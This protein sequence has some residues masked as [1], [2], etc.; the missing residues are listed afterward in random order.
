[1][2]LL[3]AC[4]TGS[5]SPPHPSHAPSKMPWWN[6]ALWDARALLRDAYNA[7]RQ[8]PT[9]F[10]V[11]RY[12]EL[13]SKYQRLL[14]R[15]KDESWKEFCSSDLNDDLFGTLK[16]LASLSNIQIPSALR[17]DN[18][19]LQDPKSILAE[20]GKSFFPTNPVPTAVQAALERSV[21]A[22][23][24]TTVGW[25][26]VYRWKGKDFFNHTQN[27]IFFLGFLYSEFLGFKPHF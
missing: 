25:C 17:V 23:V 19:T 14:R 13:K 3:R 7:K 5:K 2:T 20:F 12:A 11:S 1:M 6:K 21:E 16:K 4:A 26:S 18:V 9:D 15:S 8:H 27:Q 22:A 24:S 10:N